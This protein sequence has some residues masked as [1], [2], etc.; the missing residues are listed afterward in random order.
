MPYK[1]YEKQKENARENYWKN[2]ERKKQQATDYYYANHEKRKKQKREWELKNKEKMIAYRKKYA[3]EYKKR[4]HLEEKARW[5]LHNA[6][7]K[8]EIK[9]IKT[10]EECKTKGLMHAHHEDYSKPLE[11]IWLCHQ[12]HFIRHRKR[13]TTNE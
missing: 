9:Q 3:V 4:K 11:I 6:I 5:I 13:R 10:C 7:K 1:D 2:T 8:G 12:C